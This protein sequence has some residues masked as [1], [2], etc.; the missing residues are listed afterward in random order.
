MKIMHGKKG[1]EIDFLLR[2]MIAMAVLV[3]CIVLV[4]TV[5]SGSDNILVNI[6]NRIKF[7]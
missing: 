6:I 7:G 4:K 5:T 2:L 3:L 1:I